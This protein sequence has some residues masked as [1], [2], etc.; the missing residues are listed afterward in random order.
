MNL[1]NNKIRS[2]CFS[3]SVNII[4][5]HKWDLMSAV[6]LERKPVITK[7][8][9]DIE[10][11]FS[12]MLSRIEFEKSYKSEHE[13]RKEADVLRAELLKHKSAEV[14]DI[15]QGTIQTAQ[16]FE[17]AT[18][19][20][21]NKF[22]FMPRVTEA[23]KIKNF[24]SVDRMLE[25]H[26]LLV[27]HQKLWDQKIWIMPQGLRMDGETLLQTAERI[28]K[29]TCGSNLRVK[30][31]GNAPCGIYKFRYPKKYMDK[32]TDSSIGA[33]VFFFKAQHIAGNVEAEKL[34]AKSFKWLGRKELEKDLTSEYYKSISQF[35]IDED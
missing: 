15:D 16:D 28:L 7:S 17:D 29:D 19:D 10:V 14:D 31:S 18:T 33:K 1:I 6:C 32:N 2:C 20:E 35:L 8:L 22:T 4:R 3:T 34:T 23:D 25:N 21:Y 26:L 9:N 11:N 30:F 12:K 5:K 24:N 13:M 27:V